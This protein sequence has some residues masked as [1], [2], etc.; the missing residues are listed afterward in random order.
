M[1]PQVCSICGTMAEK[2]PPDGS[3]NDHVKCPTCGKYNISGTFAATEQWPITDKSRLS[4]A[5]RRISENGSV[6]DLDE[7]TVGSIA[8]SV[9]PPRNPLDAIDRILRLIVDKSERSD[10]YVP[11]VLAHDYPLVC[12]KSADEFAY[13]IQKAGDLEYLEQQ[14]DAYRLSLKGWNRFAQLT[15]VTPRSTSAFVAM[16]FSDKL[17]TA[18]KEA[19]S[20]G[21][22]ECGFH[23]TR[24]DLQQ[25]N[26]KICDRIVAEIKNSAFV[27]A[28]FTGQRGGVYFEAGLAMGLGIPVIWTVRKSDLKKL[29]FDT[30]Q[31][32]HIAWIS[33]EQLKTDLINRIRATIPKPIP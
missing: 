27:V 32:N 7:R 4:A 14:Q 21:I 26:E 17:E 33:P 20:P 2:F 23:P 30:R 25:H 16:W 10:R 3:N 6:V 29:H 5:V 24:M 11:I 18:W 15:T 1:V 9:F 31:Y 19:I 22:E 12:A 8:E 28:D 13:Y